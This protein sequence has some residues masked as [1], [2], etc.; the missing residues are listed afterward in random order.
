M[1]KICFSDAL[2]DKASPG[3]AIVSLTYE[4]FPLGSFQNDKYLMN[5]PQL[6]KY[7]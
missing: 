5:L 3:S 4:W 1:S 6:I 2:G 7:G